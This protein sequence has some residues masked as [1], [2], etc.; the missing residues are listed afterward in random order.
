MS[1]E[2]DEPAF[3]QSMN[4][5]HWSGMWMRDY[6]AAKAMQALLSRGYGSDVVPAMAYYVADSMVKERGK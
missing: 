1:R 5:S 3:P 4:G 6:F 2:L